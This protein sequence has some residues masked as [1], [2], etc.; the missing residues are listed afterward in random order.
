MN[1][2]KN[3]FDIEKEYTEEKDVCCY[4]YGDYYV[5][6]ICINLGKKY[7]TLTDN[8]LEAAKYNSTHR[9]SPN[10]MEKYFVEDNEVDNLNLKLKVKKIT[11][12][13][14]II[15]HNVE[16]YNLHHELFLKLDKLG[17]T[18][19]DV[20][21][22]STELFVENNSSIIK[23][24]DFEKIYGEYGKPFDKKYYVFLKDGRILTNNLKIKDEIWEL[25]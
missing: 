9:Y 14:S 24:E 11:E 19:K 1:V 22:I 17:K 21:S 25:L 7:I 15:M 12:F 2:I 16:M 23:L 13:K 10:L 4:M 18:K 5:K 3:S 8:W 6:N 20:S